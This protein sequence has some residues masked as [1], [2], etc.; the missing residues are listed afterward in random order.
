MTTNDRLLAAAKDGNSADIQQIIN[1]SLS[2]ANYGAALEEAARHNRLECAKI[3][4]PLA[5]QKAHDNALKAAMCTEE[6]AEDMP[7]FDLIFPHTSAAGRTAALEAC[8]H[9]GA[10]A[11]IVAHL[12]ANGVTDP[13]GKALIQAAGRGDEDAVNLLIP[14]S[15]PTAKNSQALMV[16]LYYGHKNCAK[17]LF[18]V[19]HPHKVW[20]YLNTKF[21]SDPKWKEILNQLFA[22]Q[23]HTRLTSSIAHPEHAPPQSRKM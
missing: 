19:S 10:S 13:H 20:A 17:S 8:V 23:Q 5:T 7:L 2:T 1:L 9:C 15:K 3:L 14:V 4:I 11:R 21:P 18:D 12:I 16:A 6:G 22:Q